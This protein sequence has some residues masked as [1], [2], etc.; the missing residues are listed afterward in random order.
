VTTRDKAI[1]GV[2]AAIVVIGAYWF[3]LL[4]PVR[5]Q[6][7]DVDKQV[8]TQR[9]SLDQA[10]SVLGASRAARAT[11]A[12]DYATVARLGKAVP[13][14][15]DVPSLVYELQSASD[16]SQIDFRSI[17]LLA[18][19]SSGGSTA[20]SSAGGSQSGSA[21][22][23]GAKAG[24][25]GGS[26]GG[27]QSGGGSGSSGSGSSG[28]QGGAGSASASG[29]QSG[30]GSGSQSGGGSGSS[31]SGSS[32]SQSGSAGS[33][34]S[35]SGSSGSQS[36]SQSGSTGS[37]AQSGASGSAPATQAAAAALPP[38]AT[39]G[40]AGFPTMPFSFTFE[41]DFFRLS[42]FFRKLERFIRAEPGRLKVNGRLLTIDGIALTTSD[43]GFPKVTA[44][45]VA[46]AYLLP[47]A[48]GL[49]GG[50]TP[51]GPGPAAPSG[52]A[53]SGGAA[54][55]S[56]ASPSPTPAAATATAP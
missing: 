53:T 16:H 10:Q 52:G 18:S 48:Q 15:D 26:G 11:Y 39:V 22:G 5:K 56:G 47:D 34:S 42:D 1:L 49:L 35:G 19:D 21:S 30:A 54:A 13:V 41:G 2:V 29:S 38:G 55:T 20:G 6:G 40:P 3:L 27:S 28:S 14:D 51:A 9:K 12:V 43:E 23:G 17:K 25:S 46:T 7:T 36:G 37:G 4:A 45:I 24:A 44:S 50:A 8:I 32:G 31:G 33:G